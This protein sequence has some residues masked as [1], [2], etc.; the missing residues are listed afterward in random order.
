M[1]KNFFYLL[2][3]CGLI[4]T[5]VGCGGG[6]ETTE[7]EVT[8]QNTVE[9]V[10]DMYVE[11]IHTED[12]DLLLETI[13]PFSAQ[14]IELR[15]YYDK[16]FAQYDYD[17]KKVSAKVLEE[18]ETSAVVE[19]VFSK[20]IVKEKGEGKNELVEGEITQKLTFKTQTEE[21]VIDKVE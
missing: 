3:I 10:V 5:L 19:L 14:H 8:S 15:G 12:I 2:S 6:S 13:H 16:D 21:W 17:V 20:T 7:S 11:A 18:S 1:K 4:L 9:G